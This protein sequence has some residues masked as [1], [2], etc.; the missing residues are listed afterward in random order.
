M[1]VLLNLSTNFF[2]V[3][4]LQTTKQNE[5]SDHWITGDH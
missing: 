1:V 2:V 5:F 4:N 3:L